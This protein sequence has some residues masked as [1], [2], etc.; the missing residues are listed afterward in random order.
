M[1]PDSLSSSYK[2]Y[3]EDTNIFSTW[4]GQTTIKCGYKP[5]IHAKRVFSNSSATSES[6]SYSA[7]S[8]SS[9]FSSASVASTSSSIST[10]S[11]SN[12]SST[13]K[14]AN[15][16]TTSTRLKG[17]ARKNAKKAKVSATKPTTQVHE[18]TVVIISTRDLVEQAKVIAEQKNITITFPSVIRR[19]AERAILARKR[20]LKWFQQAH[21]EDEEVNAS[22]EHFIGVLETILDILK[23]CYESDKIKSG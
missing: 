8:S 20:F 12:S 22:H 17:K 2:R 9:I 13:S 21:A 19:V 11:V 23:P 5:D 18:L 6:S 7:S 10:S 1:L 16:P 3:K 14:S 4:L 15:P